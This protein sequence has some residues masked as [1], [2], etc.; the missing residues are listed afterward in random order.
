LT[1]QNERLYSILSKK[2][3]KS[4]CLE[5]IPKASQPTGSI[6]EL[7][8][9]II[10]INAK[11]FSTNQKLQKDEAEK[12]DDHNKTARIMG[13]PQTK[14]IKFRDVGLED[15]EQKYICN[16]DFV[17]KSSLETHLFA[18]RNSQS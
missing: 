5:D 4:N 13:F 2:P 17:T 3:A 11:L 18:S 12:T 7:I 9:D 1:Q 15:N 16:Y 8:A 6:K 10:L 14:A